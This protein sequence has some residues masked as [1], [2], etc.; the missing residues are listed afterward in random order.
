MNFKEV[1]Q[2]SEVKAGSLGYEINP[3]LPLLEGGFTLR[4]KEEIV[5]RSLALFSTVAAAYGFDKEKATEWAITV[6]VASSLAFSEKKFLNGGNGDNLFIQSQV[7]ALNAFAWS[8]NI[9]GALAFDIKC[10]NNLITLFP[11]IK[12][13]DN[14]AD[15]RGKAKLRSVEEIVSAYD[16]S[17]CLHWAV[18]QALLDGESLP[19][20]ISPHVIIERRRALEW[21]LSSENWDDLSLDT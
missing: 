17:Y 18:T 15:Y 19:N 1:R 20:S 10:Q 8:L 16:L 4:T 6:G 11:D 12:N 3:Y 9:V 21:M 2:S 7:E 14:A 5:D 13:G